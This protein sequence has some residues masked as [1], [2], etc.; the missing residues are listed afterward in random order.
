MLNVLIITYYYPP[1]NGV[2]GWRPY[3]WFKYFPEKNIHTTVLTR[4]WLGN[5]TVWE[6]SIKENLQ[7]M[8]IV[9]DTKSRLIRLPYK[10]SSLKKLAEVPFFKMRI[11]SQLLFLF[12]KLT[13]NFSIE[14]DAYRLFKTYASD[15]LEKNKVDLIIISAPPHN[16]VRLGHYLF[17]K[18]RVPFIIDFRDLWNN[19]EL[20]K[21]YNP[22]FR[23]RIHNLISKFYIKRWLKNTSFVTTVSPPLVN[24]IK[25][26]TDKEVV[27]ITN[28]FEEELFSDTQ[29]LPSKEYF[30]ISIIG[31]IYEKQDISVIIN[32][33][34]RFISL[35]DK[36]KIKLNFIGTKSIASV[37]DKIRKSLPQECI[38][39]TERLPRETAIRYTHQSHVLLYA[40]WKNYDGIYSGKIFDYIGARRNILIAP[41]DDNVIDNIVL[42]THSGKIAN[43]VEAFSTTLLEWYTEWQKTGTVTYKGIESSINHYTRENQA[44]IF[45]S[46]ILNI[47][48]KL[49]IREA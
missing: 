41:G 15:Y 14:V 4:H 45:T 44:K 48:H 46:Y 6:D 27:E 40:G 7:E 30:T 17:K 35:T 2:Q 8:T 1:C 3:S 20:K 23:I 42:S 16:L 34:N 25:R 43:T 38:F 47:L 32:G 19:D 10:H 11:V 36:H 28:G 22:S 24:K 33:L 9:E 12:Y 29:T 26:L 21:D 13:G 39:L 5:E 37:G 31:S 18:Y 49:G